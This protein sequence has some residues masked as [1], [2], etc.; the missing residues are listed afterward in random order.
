[1]TT[2]RRTTAVLQLSLLAASPARGQQQ[3]D[4]AS[5]DP[6]LRG[7]VEP[8]LA[9]LETGDR[10][11]V[12]YLDVDP[13][14]RGDGGPSL[15]RRELRFW[16]VEPDGRLLFGARGGERVYL[17]PARLVGIERWRRDPSAGRPARVL[18]VV[19][20]AALALE[21]ARVEIR[22]GDGH[23]TQLTLAAALLGFG[24]GTVLGHAAE[25]ERGRWQPV[26]IGAGHRP[27]GPPA[28]F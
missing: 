25:G 9:P 21:V 10:V 2:Q 24:M 7:S 20:G 14:D 27:A 15:V 12:A 11:R 6:A 19:F 28:G 5:S 1:M 26:P 16:Q 4:T 17:A 8:Y 18:G 13:G 23:P 22:D 3:R